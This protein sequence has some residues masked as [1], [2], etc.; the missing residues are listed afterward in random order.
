[1][2]PQSPSHVHSNNEKNYHKHRDSHSHD[3]V[4][5]GEYLVLNDNKKEKLIPSDNPEEESHNMSQSGSDS[6]H[7]AHE[8]SHTQDNVLRK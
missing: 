2:N 8:N 6:H 3:K 1:M 5:K 4:P 7:H